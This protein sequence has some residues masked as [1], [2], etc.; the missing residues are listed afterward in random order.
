VWCNSTDVSERQTISA[1]KVELAAKQETAE[2]MTAN[3]VSFLLRLLFE[4]E[5]RGSMFIETA[6]EL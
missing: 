6:A 1:F 3:R 5:D 2:M 4:P